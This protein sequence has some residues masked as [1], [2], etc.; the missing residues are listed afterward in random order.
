MSYSLLKKAPPHDAP[1]FIDY[2]RAN[3]QVIWEDED[4]IVIENC[5]YHT[6]KKP[7]YTCFY[8]G[9]ITDWG[10]AFK[11]FWNKYGAYEWLVKGPK[12]RTVTRFHI[13]VYQP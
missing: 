7:W 11:T 9:Q 5:K 8:K 13:H 10:R 12:R 4:W 6:K 3:N 2:L 1:E